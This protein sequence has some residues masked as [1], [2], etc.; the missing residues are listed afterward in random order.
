VTAS[1][2]ID[3]SGSAVSVNVAG[4]QVNAFVYAALPSP[5]TLSPNTTYYVV[6][7][8]TA[9]GDSY[10]NFNTTVQTASAASDISSVGSPDGITYTQSGGTNQMTGP[11][12]FIYL[13]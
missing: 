6:S 7:Q 4:G 5:V 1:T 12:S 11:V 10:Y 13:Q 2:G 3:V 9:G 8:E